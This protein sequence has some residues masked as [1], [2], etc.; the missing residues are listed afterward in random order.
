V[1]SVNGTYT[2][3]TGGLAWDFS[4]GAGG[5]GGDAFHVDAGAR[6][7]SFGD[8]LRRGAGGPCYSQCPYGPPGKKVN[9][10][11]GGLVE[12]LGKYCAAGGSANGCAA[13]IDTIGTPSA[14]QGFGFSLVVT[15]A[16]GQKQGQFVFS[17]NG[18]ALN[19]WGNSGSFLCVASPLWRGAPL[20]GSGTSGACNGAFSYD[21]NAHWAQKPA[22]NPGAGSLVQVQ[23]WY[24]DPANTSNQDVALSE[25]IEFP[26]CP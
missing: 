10:T 1:Q 13:A 8:T 12:F 16:E 3:G 19:A 21:L 9:E 22:Q 23:L 2:G 26:V 5:A 18:Q 6:V 24:R 17:S 14:S 7:E 25:A 20:A 4:A 15:G 11:A